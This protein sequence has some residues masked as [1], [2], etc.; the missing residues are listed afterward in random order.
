MFRTLYKDHSF[1]PLI[2]L[3]SP[4]KI[5][6][7]TFPGILSKVLETQVVNV[8]QLRLKNYKDSDLIFI[9]SLLAFLGLFFISTTL[10][11]LYLLIKIFRVQNAEFVHNIFSLPSK[12]DKMITEENLNS[13]C[14]DLH[15]AH[16]LIMILIVSL[17]FSF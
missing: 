15:T 5:D 13:F 3:I 11:S 17:I 12:C 8:F 14:I 7:K 9:T 10:W 4:S 6:I 2:Y 16:W 1:K